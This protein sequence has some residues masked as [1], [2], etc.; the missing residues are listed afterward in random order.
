MAPLVRVSLSK[1]KLE[2]TLAEIECTRCYSLIITCQSYPNRTSR[3]RLSC[4]VLPILEPLDVVKF[5][6]RKQQEEN[7]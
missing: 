6:S 1:Y 4:C 7:T 5:Q 2:R 3:G